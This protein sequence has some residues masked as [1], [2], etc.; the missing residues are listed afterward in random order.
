MGPV[1]AEVTSKRPA[2]DT[3][4]SDQGMRVLSSL[5]AGIASIDFRELRGLWVPF[6]LM[7]VAGG[8]VTLVY[9]R[10]LCDRVYP[11]YADESFLSM[12]GMLCGTI[13]SGI[14]LLRPIDP[15]LETPAANNLVTGS[16][17]GIVLGVPMLVFIGLAAESDTMLAVTAGLIVVYLTVLV[18]LLLRKARKGKAAE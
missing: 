2:H 6:L 4:G 7:A 1:K 12:Y 16:S 11:A 13:S 3:G 18:W 9:L 15:N 10:W 8:V 17:F 5:I 14:L